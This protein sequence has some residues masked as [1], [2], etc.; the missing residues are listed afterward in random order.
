MPASAFANDGGP[1]VTNNSFR[2]LALFVCLMCLGMPGKAHA[3]PNCQ[4]A[5][6]AGDDDGDDPFRESRAY[7][8]SIYL[9]AFMPYLLFGGLGV[10]IYRGARA[11][12]RRIQEIP[13]SQPPEPPDAT[14]TS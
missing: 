10:A 12:D 2:I 13:T 8:Q 11:A 4:D 1:V 7:N 6:V 3:C 5:L 14:T 9:M